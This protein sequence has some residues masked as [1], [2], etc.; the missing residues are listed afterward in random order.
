MMF[1]TFRPFEWW[2]ARSLTSRY[3]GNLHVDQWP[4]ARRW[5]SQLFAGSRN[6]KTIS[7]G[8]VRFIHQRNSLALACASDLG[9]S[10]S[11]SGELSIS[12]LSFIPII[13]LVSLRL[14]LVSSNTMQ[15]TV[16]RR[17]SVLT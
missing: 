17:V 3:D 9:S 5:T 4:P 13:G 10:S 6:H 2:V 15:S 7:Y 16:G 1:K 8:N 12:C 14:A 11:L